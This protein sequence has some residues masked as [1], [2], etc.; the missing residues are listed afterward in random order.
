MP[1]DESGRVETADVDLARQLGLWLDE[2]P[3]LRE[4]RL[5]RATD[6]TFVLEVTASR[7]GRVSRQRVPLTGSE[8]T[9]LR[10]DVSARIAARA[11]R[12]GMDQRGRNLLLGQSALAGVVFYGWAVPYLLGADDAPGGGLFLAS[13]SASFFVP[14]VLTRNRP[15]SYGMANLSR[16]GTTRGI[17]H[18]LLLYNLLPGSESGTICV[19]RV[20][21]DP[22]GSDEGPG[23]TAFALFT[24]VAEGVGGYLWARNEEM[25]AGTANAISLGGD[26]GLLW[27]LGSAYLV[28]AEDIGKRS[29]AAL[30]LPAS[31][32]GMVAG[33]RLAA[34][35][36]YL[37]G[38]VE[39]MYTT[40][41]LGAYAGGALV[42]LV[43][44]EADPGIVAAAI[45]GSA[46]GLVAGDRLVK[47]ADI[48]VGQAMLNR[49]GTI[50]GG[51]AG[52]SVGVMAGDEKV[53][54]LGG[55]IGGLAG[56]ALTYQS[57]APQTGPSH[58]RDASAL[59]VHLTP[60]ALLGAAMKRD[61][62]RPAP[63]LPLLNVE[64]TF[65]G[66]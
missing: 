19:D 27:G 13:S 66:R 54:V 11:P 43:D 23:R 65:G 30:A 15:V 55:A 4:V 12:I 9:A 64:Y 60:G 32:A 57:L 50:A 39:V 5:F 40:G 33:H 7:D 17:A 42:S 21:C 58:G 29:T 2:Y 34:Q 59:R 51:L 52:A 8:V 41:A 36:D 53:A 46:A 25:S 1:L 20:D 62:G 44:D 48:T 56:F 28:G 10:R 49:L 24:S 14:F 16:Y 38:D 26:V 45:V 3:G 37:W 31:V 22:G 61:A 63:T 18:G 35:R 6:T 47:G